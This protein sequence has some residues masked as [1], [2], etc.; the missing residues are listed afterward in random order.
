[1]RN[2]SADMSVIRIDPDLVNLARAYLAKRAVDLGVI[3]SA[4]QRRDFETIHRIG[5][6]MHGSGQ[7]FGFGELTA[8]GAQLQRAVEARDAARIL[9]LQRRM[10][11]FVSSTEVAGALVDEARPRR[12]GGMDGLTAFESNAVLVVDDDEMNRILITHYLEKEGYAVTQVSSGEEALRVLED[13]PLPALILLDVVMPGTSGLEV[14]RRIK[15]HPSTGAIPV[16]L[17][18]ALEKN[19]DRARGMDAG[20]DDFITKPVARADLLARVAL[21]APRT[22]AAGR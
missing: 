11:H 17:L 15:A 3:E 12:N 19:E 8:I 6:N 5:H 20:A 14:C 1:M 16:V 22:A 13:P 4:L 21:L 7:M 9:R 10:A 18:T 2:R